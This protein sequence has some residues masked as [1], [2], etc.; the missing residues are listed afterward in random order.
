MRHL[1]VA[2]RR[3]TYEQAGDGPN[4]VLLHGAVTDLRSWGDVVNL[5]AT[6]FRVTAFDAPGCG[7]SDDPESS[8]GMDDYADSVAGFLGELQL[9]PAHLVGHSWGSSLALATHL[10][11]PGV[12]R[13]LVLAGAYAGWSGSL[14]PDAV[15][16]RL[17]FAHQVADQL[18]SGP[19]WDPTSMP[20]L[21]SDRISAA[22]RA[23]LLETMRAIRA[24]GT[25][26]M[27][28]A[29]ATCDLRPALGE[30]TVPTL[31]LAG[32]RDERSSVAV[33][34]TLRA[35]IPGSTLSVLPGLGHEMFAEDP[36][37]CCDAVR[38]FLAHT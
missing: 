6:A 17:G 19:G 16:Q 32:E 22:S 36:R 18:E 2:G 23:R 37:A 25:R 4:L 11:H 15:A 7:G 29:L 26:T 10:R 35:A 20:G 5:L 30:V 14:T 38:S 21:F 28:T 33:A 3:V 9:G 12:A 13:S 24:S 8:W 1:D 27:A 34:E 31:L